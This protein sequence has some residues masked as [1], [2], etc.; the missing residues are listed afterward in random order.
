MKYIDEVIIEVFAGNGGNGAVSFRREKFIPK[1]GPD[2][3]D[4]G[5]GGSIYAVGDENL[6]TLL[7]YRFQAHIRAKKG[8]NGQGS[9]RYGKGAK[10]IVLKMP[11]G[12]RIKDLESGSLIADLTHH[13]ERVLLAKGGEGGLG[14]LHFKSST[15]R[16]PRQA[17]PGGRGEIRKLHLELH[18][19]ADVGLLGLPNAGKS[20]LIRAISAARPKVADYPFTT[21]TPNLGTVSSKG[22]GSFVI[23]DI[24]GL[25]EGAA[26][27]AGLGSR[28]LRHLSRNALL[29]HLID[30]APIDPCR[31]PENDARTV[32]QELK[33]YD[34]ALFN[35]PRWIVFTK[36]DAL[37]REEVCKKQHAVL[38][39]LKNRQFLP[40]ETRV[41]TISAL[42]HQ[43]LTELVEAI[44]LYLKEHKEKF[45]LDASSL[46]SSSFIKEK[47]TV[48]SV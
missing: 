31:N 20:T 33:N 42:N 37:E 35:K 23:A 39:H 34:E 32:L 12:T 41:F 46:S 14:N 48:E 2:G 24:P 47:E 26:Q 11:L 19:L 21:L 7:P 36:S 43:G 44:A 3:G 10:D 9:D 1:G 38:N 17:T 13:G 22:G 27:G 18:S 8:E 45:D 25:I 4:G 15:N 29:L 30:L 5:K 40:P 28:F 6:N 16:T